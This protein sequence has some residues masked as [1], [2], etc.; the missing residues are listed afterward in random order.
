MKDGEKPAIL[1]MMILMKVW[2]KST[3]DFLING[4]KMAMF[5]H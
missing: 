1:M 2:S 3:W 4:L 5:Y